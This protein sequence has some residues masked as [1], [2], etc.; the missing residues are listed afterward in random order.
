MPC[1]YS[2]ITYKISG[3]EFLLSV[4][5]KEGY[6]PAN[7]LAEQHKS[8]RENADNSSSSDGAKEPWVQANRMQQVSARMNFCT[9]ALLDSSLRFFNHRRC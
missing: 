2:M 9:L 6:I 4:I 7:A 8:L 5:N 1:D 3:V